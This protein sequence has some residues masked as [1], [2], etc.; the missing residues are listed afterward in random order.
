MDDGY[1]G[2]CCPECNQSKF[3]RFW[4]DRQWTLDDGAC[5]EC[6]RAAADLWWEQ[7]PQRSGAA[8]SSPDSSGACGDPPPNASSAQQEPAKARARAPPPPPRGVDIPTAAAPP[9]LTNEAAP[10]RYPDL[11]TAMQRMR[12]RI[13]EFEAR[14]Q[15]LE[16]EKNVLKQRLQNFEQEKNVLEQRLLK[17]EGEKKQDGSG[18]T[19]PGNGRAIHAHGQ[20]T[21]K[22]PRLPSPEKVAFVPELDTRLYHRYPRRRPTSDP[23]SVRA[24]LYDNPRTIGRDAGVQETHTGSESSSSQEDLQ[25]SSDHEVLAATHPT[26]HAAGPPSPGRALTP[27]TAPPKERAPSPAEEPRHTAPTQQEE[28]GTEE[29]TTMEPPP[30]D[31]DLKDDKDHDDTPDPSAQG[32][33]HL[34][35]GWQAEGTAAEATAIRGV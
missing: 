14:L 15:N 27:D 19:S 2:K 12:E 10:Q 5:K 1:E 23:Y 31:T 24:G 16:Q 17:L 30:T 26:R 7:K 25:S 22:A 3:R 13:A 8:R 9:P 4:G 29:V 11:I 6:N 33:G 34:H 32:E 20:E 35:A 21:S 18:G 28:P